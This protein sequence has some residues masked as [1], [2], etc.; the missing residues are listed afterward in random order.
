MRLKPRIRQMLRGPLAA[1]LAGLVV[2][3]GAVPAGAQQSTEP[4]HIV[5]ID[6][7]DGQISV[8]LEIPASAVG[9]TID[10]VQMRL[11]DGAELDA[12]AGSLTET[13]TTSGLD[14]QT[15]LVLDTSTSMGKQGR[16]VAAKEAA[17]AFVDGL[18]A[19]VEVGLI[20]FAS[21]ARVREPTRDH[22]AVKAEIR[23]LSAAGGTA[24]FDAVLLALDS[25]DTGDVRNLVVLTDDARDQSSMASLEQAVDRLSQ[26]RIGLDVVTFANVTDGDVLTQLTEAA[27]GEL[28]PARQVDDVTRLFQQSAQTIGAQ[29]LITAPVPEDS[30]PGEPMVEV[31][32]RA[33]SATLRDQALLL[34]DPEDITAPTAAPPLARVT[35]GTGLLNSPG[36]LATAAALLFLGLSVLLMYA[37]S[38]AA[39][40]RR[41]AGLRRR[42]AHY[43]LSS[44][45]TMEV[46]PP[47]FP[48]DESTG[49]NRISTASPGGRTG[50]G[51]I[52]GES[53]LARTAVSIAERVVASQDSQ[54]RLAA[55]LESAAIPL[56][57]PEWLVL[58]V[59]AAVL[60]AITLLLISGGDLAFALLGFLLGVFGPVVYLSFKRSGRRHRFDE[61]L[62]G[63]L[64]L[65]S[66]S[67]SAGYSLPQAV[68]TVARQASQP[69]ATE[70]GRAI[71][72]SR[73]GVPIEDALQHVAERTGS[74][75]FGWVVMAIRIQRQVGGNLA[76][77]LNTIAGTLRERER[78]RRQVRVLSA[79][80]RLS[81]WILGVLPLLFA[82][83]LFVARRDYLM[84][85]FTEPMGIAMLFVGVLALG[86]G[87]FWMKK[88]V[89]VEV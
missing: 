34:L 55:R 72:E 44:V 43:S 7:Q 33:G 79:E 89:D 38:A 39:A 70:Y 42:L 8:V 49:G 2:F 65:L 60:P 48:P 45:P 1:V 11:V 26:S 66:G 50:A 68:D 84:K 14:R 27:G 59:A 35:T 81:A 78:L 9:A 40:N 67:L 57:A 36:L 13:G 46:T 21:D 87:M 3:G 51:T 5:F 41:E 30:Q 25:L 80:G 16:L 32:V 6:A 63:T 15:M 4:D 10:S 77:L 58:H 24:I 29:L 37:L 74:Q 75:D 82:M 62:P 83:Y 88:I 71:M 52:L 76:E 12:T 54:G 23:D 28:V 22:E 61:Q 31:V 86:I 56:R 64:Q 18:P 69:V 17:T 47:G 73:L 19:D 53:G 20:T 85:L